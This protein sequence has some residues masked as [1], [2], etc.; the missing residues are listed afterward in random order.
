MSL[1]QNV[2]RL[3]QASQALTPGY[4][5][6]LHNHNFIDVRH[7]PTTDY[8]ASPAPVAAANLD[9]RMMADDVRCTTWLITSLIRQ[10]AVALINAVTQFYA[11]HQDPKS[12]QGSSYYGPLQGG[13]NLFGWGL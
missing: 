7:K 1:L 13:V 3:N 8:L 5:P 9:N 11:D 6:E 2:E 12:A 4:Q 10:N